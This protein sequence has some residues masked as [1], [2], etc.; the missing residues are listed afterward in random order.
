MRLR[1]VTY[2]IHKCIGGLDRRYDPLRVAHVIARYEPDL[3]LLQEVDQHARRS[4]ADRQV[5]LLGDFLGLRHRTYF[6]NVQ[7]RGGGEY[8]NAMLSRFPMTESANIDLTVSL[9]KRRSVLHARYRIRLGAGP[10]N[11][12][13]TIHAYNLH[14]GLSGIERRIQLRRF[15]ESH[16]FVGLHHQT[17]ILV[18]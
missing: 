15:L 10:G 11:P 18:A 13:R 7:V 3:V 4:N 8:G 17:P 12:V 1:I 5:D 6:P 14:L 2:N 9:K 16:P